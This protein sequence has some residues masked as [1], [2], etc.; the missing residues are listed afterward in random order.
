MSPGEHQAM[1]ELTIPATGERNVYKLI[2]KA[3]E[4]VAESHIVVECQARKPVH[5][6]ITVCV[7]CVWGGGPNPECLGGIQSAWEC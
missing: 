6:Q 7:R 4:P 1:L 5:K 3:S 2:G